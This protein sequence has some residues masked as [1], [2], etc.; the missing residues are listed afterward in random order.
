MCVRAG[1]GGRRPRLL[2]SP[3]LQVV[4]AVV[5]LLWLRLLPVP[6][7]V[8]VLQLLLQPLF[9]TQLVLRQPLQ[10]RPWGPAGVDNAGSSGFLR[11]GSFLL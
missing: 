10:V 6:V 2:F 5:L 4:I 8:L 7:P 1:A 9:Q 11:D 3:G